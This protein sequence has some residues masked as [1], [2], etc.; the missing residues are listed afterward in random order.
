MRSPESLCIQVGESLAHYLRAG[1]G[2][3]LVLVHGGSSDSRDWAGTMAELA[4]D[5]SL[6]A[7]DLVGY[8]KTS[9]DKES[10]FLSDLVGFTHDFISTLGLG[11][12]VLVGHSLGGRVC[13]EIALHHPEQVSRLVLV[14][15]VGF[16][17][18][19]RSGNALIMASRRL[20]KLVRKSLSY[21][22]LLK[23]DGEPEHWLCMDKL[24]QL[25]MPTLLIWKRY[26]PYF[27]LSLP[28]K[29]KKLIPNATLVVVPGYGHAPHK[30]NTDLFNRYLRRFL[31]GSVY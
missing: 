2:P 16:G 13:L 22:V 4:R 26:D 15:T 23:G 17:P 3:P 28:L 24:P 12:P 1:E 11:S 29:A 8:G 18:V 7:P 27:P 5:Y 14:D 31:E 30:E 21:P 6:Y 19:S 10:L 9:S 20:R 25:K